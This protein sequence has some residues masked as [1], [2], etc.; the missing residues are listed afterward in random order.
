MTT[1]VMRS[2]DG[3]QSDFGELVAGDI[4]KAAN[5]PNVT[6][7]GLVLLSDV[8][9]ALGTLQASHNDLLAKLKAAGLM[10]PD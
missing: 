2:V 7:G 10:V 8:V 6:T 3:A 9:T 1:K 4:P 5:V